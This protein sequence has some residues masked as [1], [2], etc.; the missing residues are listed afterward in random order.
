MCLVDIIINYINYINYN[1]SVYCRVD[2]EG[3]KKNRNLEYFLK[4]Y[5]IFFDN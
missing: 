2:L 3:E 5:Y 1:I 4:I